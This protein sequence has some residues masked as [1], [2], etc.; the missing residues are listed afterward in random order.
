MYRIEIVS[1]NK[2]TL[3]DS[4][5]V[6]VIVSCSLRR[7]V[8]TNFWIET[9]LVFHCQYYLSKTIFFRRSNRPLTQ[10]QIFNMINIDF[11]ILVALM[12]MK[13]NWVT[14]IRIN[15]LHNEKLCLSFK[16]SIFSKTEGIIISY[17]YVNTEW[18]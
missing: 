11:I 10:M 4:I 9:R 17:H 3:T 1:I 15:A 13:T 7:N 2:L 12:Y 5:F 14:K 8:I 6:F 18:N 16:H